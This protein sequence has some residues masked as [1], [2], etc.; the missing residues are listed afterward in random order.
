MFFGIGTR[1]RELVFGSKPVETTCLMA[2]P[3]AWLGAVQA[4]REPQTP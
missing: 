4:G 1:A 2:R 3:D